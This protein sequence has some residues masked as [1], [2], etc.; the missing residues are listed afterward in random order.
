MFTL[1]ADTKKPAQGGL[2]GRK[3]NLSV[4]SQLQEIHRD[5]GAAYVAGLN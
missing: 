3:F 1:Q 4:V 5:S 2:R